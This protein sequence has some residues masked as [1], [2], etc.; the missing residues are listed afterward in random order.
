MLWKRNQTHLSLLRAVAQGL[1]SPHS[2][3]NLGSVTLEPRLPWLTWVVLPQPLQPLRRVHADIIL[4]VDDLSIQDTGGPAAAAS[5]GEGQEVRGFGGG[6]AKEAAQRH[7]RASVSIL[8]TRQP[9]QGSS[10]PAWGRKR[11]EMVKVVDLRP[12]S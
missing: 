11:E 2:E 9:R 4:G 6:P 10:R 7:C 3:N 8:R 1:E 5:R 12:V